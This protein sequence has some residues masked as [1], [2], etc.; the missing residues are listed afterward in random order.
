MLHFFVPKLPPHPPWKGG[1]QWWGASAWL[2]GIYLPARLNHNTAPATQ[3]LAVFSQDNICHISLRFQ[4]LENSYP[5]NPLFAEE[6]SYLLRILTSSE[7]T[8][9]NGNT[10]KRPHA[11]VFSLTHS[12]LTPRNAQSLF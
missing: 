12:G 9:L 1:G 6:V 5:E 3:G 2:C 8:I 10:S 7:H 11:R 4:S